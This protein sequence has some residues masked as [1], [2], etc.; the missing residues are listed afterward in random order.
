MTIICWLFEIISGVIS[1][2]L[3]AAINPG[4]VVR[5]LLLS[6]PAERRGFRWKSFKLKRAK[7]RKYFLIA[8][9]LANLLPKWPLC[10]W[11]AKLR[12]QTLESEF[13]A[14]FC[15]REGDYWRGIND[16]IHDQTDIGDRPGWIY[17]LL[18]SDFEAF[19]EFR[20]SNFW[21]GLDTQFVGLYLEDCFLV[22]GLLLLLIL[23][24]RTHF[25]CFHLSNYLRGS[26]EV[27]R[28]ETF[29]N[30]QETKRISSGSGVDSTL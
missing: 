17:C 1:G 9:Q 30:L 2:F 16:V 18:T 8:N 26:L 10:V 19:F 25:Y 13:W 6:A 24:K 23:L 22:N 28:F 27:V 29:E 7:E 15:T 14:V 4:A 11:E 5:A 21:S 3:I 20:F 12:A